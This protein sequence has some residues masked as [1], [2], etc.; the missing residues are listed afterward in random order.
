MAGV[1]TVRLR[2]AATGVVVETTEVAAGRLSGFD[3]V[4][5]Q[6]RKAAAEVTTAKKETS[7][8][9]KRSSSRKKTAT[10]AAKK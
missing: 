7:A 9:K 5:Q 8:P 3:A 2:N 1:K 6:A 4:E 10:K